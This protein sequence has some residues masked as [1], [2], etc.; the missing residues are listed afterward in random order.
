MLKNLFWDR[1]GF[2]KKE[3]EGVRGSE[4]YWEEGGVL[5]KSIKVGPILVGFSRR[6]RGLGVL[7]WE[8]LP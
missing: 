8:H 4:I 2:A 3:E 6:E 5:Q 7:V 1:G